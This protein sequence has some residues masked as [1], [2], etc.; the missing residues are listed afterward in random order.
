MDSKFRLLIVQDLEP[1]TRSA[2][3]EELHC[4]LCAG[5]YGCP[6]YQSWYMEGYQL[7]DIV[8]VI[9]YE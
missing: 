6:K 8:G 1:G 7:L 3:I 5:I 2:Q 4:P 9:E